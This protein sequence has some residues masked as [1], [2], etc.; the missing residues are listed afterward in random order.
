MVTWLCFL[1]NGKRFGNGPEEIHDSKK[2][3]LML[4]L[5]RR[6][7]NLCLYLCRKKK[8]TTKNKLKM[9]KV[10]LFKQLSNAGHGCV[11][12][13]SF[14]TSLIL[15]KLLNLISVMYKVNT[16]TNFLSLGFMVKCHNVSTVLNALNAFHKC[17]LYSFPLLI[18]P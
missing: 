13:H 16:H 5:K 14:V 12:G 18:K 4:F 8:T 15:H 2:N 17:Q 9:S 7:G 11:S 6:E 10:F 3:N 1:K